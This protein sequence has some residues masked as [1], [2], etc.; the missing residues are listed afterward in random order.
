[1][2]FIRKHF[3][4][5]FLLALGIALIYSNSLNASFQ[6]DDLQI[7]DRP[8][9]RITNLNL[10]SLKGT[11]FWS[12]HQKRIY[13]PLPCL[14]LGLNFYFGRDNP[15]GYHITNITIHFL[16]AIAVYVFLQTLLSIPGIR[17]TFA[18]KYRYEIAV[19]A[20]FL[21]AFHPIQT[22]V[23]TY[24]IQRMTSL[25]AFFYII[26]VTGYISFRKQSLFPS[27]S[28]TFIKYTSLSVSIISCVFSFLSKENSAILPATILFIDYLF[29]YDL[30]DQYEKKKLRRIYAIFIFLLLIV[31]AYSGPKYLISFFEGYKNRDFSL[32]ERLLTEPRVVFYYLYL[33]LIPSINLL[34][35]NHDVLISRSLVNPPQ[36][37]F[38]ILG[39]L[40]LVFIACIARKKYNLFSFVIVWYLGNL[41]IE[42]T[43]IPVELIYEHRTYL[44]GVLVFFLLS[45]CIVYVSKHIFKTN[46][47]ILFTSLLLVLYGNGTYTRNFVFKSP[48]SMWLDVVPKSP[49]LART[50]SNLGKAYMDLGYNLEARKSFEKALRLDPDIPE[51]LVNLGKIYFERFGME[52]EGMAVLKKAQRVR[53][54][55]AIGCVALAD[56]YSKLKKY[57]KAEHFYEAAI[58]RLSL[59]LYAIN[60]LGITKVHLGKKAEAMKLFQWGISIDPTFEPLHLNLARLLSDENEFPDAIETLKRFVEMN[61]DS[62]R[63]KE[64]LK[65]IE[66]KD[67]AI[68]QVK[69]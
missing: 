18:A 68:N 29:F 55:T 2:S 14:T 30:S 54:R 12:P 22:N 44:P 47:A 67:N 13:R 4:P 37:Y 63:V 56:G 65:V 34:N 64:L 15:Y 49:N 31:L 35:L 3:G 8:N 25:A 41:I 9:L 10:Q 6:F 46:K 21:F 51:A 39:I 45:F 43:I 61:G 59:S 69:G 60:N 50:H 40:S 32:V 28:H 27:Q 11:F 62:K 5:L 26:S 38:A 7:K 23:V 1:M 16:C 58:R 48:L 36:T 33:L 53:K 52:D 42:S 66:E 24:I 20:T 19:I 57:E 17:P